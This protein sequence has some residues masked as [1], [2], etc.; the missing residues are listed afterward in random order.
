LEA[1]AQEETKAIEKFNPID[2]I[3]RIKGLGPKTAKALGMIGISTF[4]HI[5][6]LTDEDKIT[7]SKKIHGRLNIDKWASQA[8]K[9]KAEDAQSHES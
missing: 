6:A 2:D 7:I 3:T 4:N 5:I 9:I 8:Q 1:K